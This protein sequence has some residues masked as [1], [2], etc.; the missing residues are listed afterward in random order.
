MTLSELV[1]KYD[2]Y[3]L[4]ELTS[5]AALV[6]LAAFYCRSLP[7]LERLLQ[8]FILGG[9]LQLPIVIGQA[10]GLMDSLPGGLAQ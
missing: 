7:D 8:V 9:M 3:R 6:L 10:V 5:A 1:S 4:L 2:L